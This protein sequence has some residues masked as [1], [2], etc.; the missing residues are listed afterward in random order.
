MRKQL[1]QNGLLTRLVE[2]VVWFVE[3][4]CVWSVVEG[5]SVY[6]CECGDVYVW[7]RVC[8]ATCM[9]GNV[10]VDVR[11]DC[12]YKHRLW[13]L[14]LGLAWLALLSDFGLLFLR[15][16]SGRRLPRRHASR[17]SPGGEEGEGRI[18]GGLTRPCR[19]RR[20]RLF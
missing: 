20:R 8:V 11:T 13:H 3:G 15:T 14:E 9:C 16:K 18:L 5:V 17:S 1:T 4:V 10:C 12:E 19:A 7:R 6:V 2:G